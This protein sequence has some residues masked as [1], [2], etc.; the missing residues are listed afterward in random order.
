MDRS[1]KFVNKK[2][3]KRLLAIICVVVLAFASVT[4]NAATPK[5]TASVKAT[6]AYTLKGLKH[7][8]AVQ[9]FYIASKYIYITQ[10]SGSTTYL[11][12]LL[13]NGN[14]ARY[15][16][17][18]TLLNAG[19]GQSLDMYTYNNINYLYVGCKPETSDY[20][21]SL[22]IAR[23]QYE[24]NK[25]YDYTD[26]NRLT[27]MNYASKSSKSL[28]TTYRVA[29]GGNS[30]YTIFR[31]QTTQGSVTYSIYD[32]V[33]LN[34][35]L[36][37]NKSVKMNTADAR[38]ACKHS[39]TQT[40]SNIVRPNSS[41][42]G[43]DMVGSSK[44]FITGGADGQTPQI[45]KMSNSGAYQ[46]LIKISNVGKCEIE[47]VQCKND[48]IYFLIKTNPTSKKDTQKIYYVKESAFD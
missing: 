25:T 4:A 36:D 3:F 10:R 48:F 21:F 16:D 37:K 17:E 33:A 15:V 47:G 28:G 32:T 19:H 6:L 1:V 9:N 31:I 34:K 23:I 12:R 46:K 5:S 40:G 22:Q 7:N 44:V 27:Y 26:L 35:L 13:I 45:A 11:S 2:V 8:L 24:A 29:A 14:E 20:H 18:M 39:F 30:T 42:Q 38:K 41:F 43:I